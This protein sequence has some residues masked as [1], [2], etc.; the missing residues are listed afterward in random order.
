[1]K[2]QLN[3]SVVFIKIVI[4]NECQNKRHYLQRRIPGNLLA[5]LA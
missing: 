3:K 2:A 1:M 4:N 5:G